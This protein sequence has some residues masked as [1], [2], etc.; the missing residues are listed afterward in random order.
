MDETLKPTE[1]MGKKCIL[2]SFFFKNFNPIFVTYLYEQ[3]C[4]G[5]NFCILFGYTMQVHIKS[6]Y[7]CILNDRFLLHFQKLL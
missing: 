4:G 1:D 3:D 6:I 5:L 2:N 7:V